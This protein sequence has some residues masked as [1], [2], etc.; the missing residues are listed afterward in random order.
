MSTKPKFDARLTFWTTPEVADAFEALAARSLLSVSDHLR[1][2]THTYVSSRG[3]LAP[4]NGGAH[5]QPAE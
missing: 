3:L 5:H 4:Q 1:D 2:A